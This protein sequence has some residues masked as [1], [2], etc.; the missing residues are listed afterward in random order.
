MLSIVLRSTEGWPVLADR[1]EWRC[2]SA[3]S[4]VPEN[5]LRMSA[6]ASASR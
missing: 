6:S 4:G 1:G 3:R 2:S 5:V